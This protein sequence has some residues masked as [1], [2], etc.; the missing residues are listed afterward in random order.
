MSDRTLREGGTI[1]VTSH[2][3][4]GCA[5]LIANSGLARVVVD[6]DRADAH[7]NPLASYQFLLQCGLEIELSDLVMRSRLREGYRT[8]SGGWTVG[9][10]NIAKLFMNELEDEIELRRQYGIGPEGIV[11][12]A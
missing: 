7:R 11:D 5:K 2:V 6:A 12:G 1:Y 10:P 4:Y 9:K 3:C 8:A